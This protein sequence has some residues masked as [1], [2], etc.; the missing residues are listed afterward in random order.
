MNALHFGAGNIGRGFIGLV[1][2]KNGFEV[3][4]ADVADALIDEIKEKGEYT[5]ILAD[6]KREKIHVEGVHGINSKTEHAKLKDAVIT[7]D[8]ITTAVGPNIVPIIAK[9]LV[10]GIKERLARAEV[11]P[12]SII[13][14][15]NAVGATA[16][17]K[18]ALLK[19][20]DEV[21]KAN[22]EKYIGFPNS[23]VDRIVPLQT[24]ENML[25]V[26]VEPFFE[27]VVEKGA[28]KGDLLDIEGVHYV[29][30]LTPY[31]ERKLF[32]VNTGHA[33]TAYFGLKN[34][35]ETVLQA[36][37]DAH[38]EKMVRGVLSETSFY[39]TETYGFDKKEH[40]AYVDKIIGRF[41]NPNISDE[42]V[43]VARSPI[44]KMSRKDRFVAPA[45]GVLELGKKP[46]N[47]ARA[48]AALASSKNEND[49]ESVELNQYI[50]KHGLK[51]TLLKYAELPLDSELTDLV[52][53][54]YNH[55]HQN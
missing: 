8:I 55:I 18:E 26:Q 11:K 28:V 4:F 53:K 6:E 35:Y 23:A 16:I 49:P 15:E 45:L 13:A 36:I 17:L 51:D 33:A 44:R 42:L 34:G 12:F 39:I 21:E 14:C 43:R 48:I 37:S 52:L 40:Q 19:E 54:A 22:A 29:E 10:P 41:K 50:D 9:T 30:D 38:V 27:W 46:E 1:L 20:L 2:V 32:T 31:I 5:V 24:N 7:A 25:D 3:T 47:L